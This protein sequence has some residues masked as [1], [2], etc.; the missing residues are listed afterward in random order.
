MAESEPIF[1]P[2]ESSFALQVLLNRLLPEP[3]G[4]H[5]QVKPPCVPRKACH[6]RATE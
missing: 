5:R 6:L 4:I 2:D 1:G 3:F